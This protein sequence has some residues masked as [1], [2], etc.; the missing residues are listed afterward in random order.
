MIFSG[1]E[2]ALCTA[3][4]GFVALYGLGS[5]VLEAGGRGLP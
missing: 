1:L 4:G 5:G 2:E 3:G